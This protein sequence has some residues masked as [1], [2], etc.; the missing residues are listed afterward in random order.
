MLLFSLENGSKG[1][2]WVLRAGS[3]V[4]RLEK[5]TA[6]ALLPRAEVCMPSL[7][8]EGKTLVCCLIK[9]EYHYQSDAFNLPRLDTTLNDD[10]DG[11]SHKLTTLRTGTH[12]NT[13]VNESRQ[14]PTRRM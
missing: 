8:E 1:D 4:W 7:L 14:N 6:M 11:G 5:G 13:K 3:G 9:L 12:S 10:E 2:E